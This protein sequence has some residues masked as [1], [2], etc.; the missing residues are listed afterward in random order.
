[1]SEKFIQKESSSSVMEKVNTY[2]KA[3]LILRTNSRKQSR[4]NDNLEGGNIGWYPFF[5]IVDSNIL[6]SNKTFFISEYSETSTTIQRDSEDDEDFRVGAGDEHFIEE[7]ESETESIK[8]TQREYKK[9]TSTKSAS[10][11]SF[12]NTK[13]EE[14]TSVTDVLDRM[15]NAD[16]GK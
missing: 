6:K 4:E 7:S 16:N 3:G 8:K 9:V 2:P 11:R 14:V 10:S 15:R 13:G 12:L 5:H 1:M